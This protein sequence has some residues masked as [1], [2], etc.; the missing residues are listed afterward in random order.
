M[1]QRFNMPLSHLEIPVFN[2]VDL[3]KYNTIIM[4]GGTYTDLNKEKLK[5][6]V[7]NGGNLILT[8]EAVTW[9]SQN[10]I[11]NVM[12]K[13]IKPNADSTLRISY[14]DRSQLEGAQQMSGAIFKAEL[15]L[16]H[17]LAYGY[18]RPYISLFKANKVFMEKSK[19][20]YATPVFYQSAPLQSGWLSK[21]NY[22]AVK[23]SAAVVVN[24]V[25]SG[26]VIA[27]AD[28]PNFRAFWLGGSKLMMNAVFFGRIIDA[29]SARVE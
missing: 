12:V 24:A 17:P 10:G 9:A 15:D 18:K 11:G 3:G 13:K 23:N 25:G 22:E 19:N 29:A 1:D 2:R 4:V 26:R 20:P 6:W 28:N 7:Q 21:E 16:S 27:I 14:V 8:E 5:S